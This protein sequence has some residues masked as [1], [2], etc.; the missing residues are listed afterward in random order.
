MCTIK[1]THSTEGGAVKKIGLVGGTTPESTK[2][3]YDLLIQLARGTGGD[4]LH[5]P[6]IMIYSLDLAQLVRL[7]REEPA[8][9][10]A[11]FLA[12]ICERLQQCGAE[13]GA[14]T[15]NTPHAYLAGIEARTT[16]PMVSIV[17]ATCH[18]ARDR[19]VQRLLLLGTRT[20]MEADMY[21]VQLAEAGITMV[22]P[23][24]EDREFID[25][26]IYGEL[27]LGRVRPEVRQRF[28]DICANSVDR[29]A[30]DGVILG[31]TEIPLVISPADLPVATFDTT[32]IHVEAIL[33]AAGSP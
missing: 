1:E 2:E 30:V 21:P 10:V 4:P 17:T 11:E 29:D 12:D 32:R 25:R 18:A 7:Q 20:T 6:V 28:L 3:Y 23:P 19:G 33:A 5:N 8:D 27:S 14:L 31:C 9:R 22:L 16:L 13:I 15:A 26:T 24:S